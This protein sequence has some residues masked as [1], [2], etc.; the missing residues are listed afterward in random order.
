MTKRKSSADDNEWPERAIAELE[1]LPTHAWENMVA[2]WRALPALRPTMQRR[3]LA[4]MIELAAERGDP[5]SVK[6]VKRLNVNQLLRVPPR[7]RSR[8]H[9]QNAFRKAAEYRAA[10]PKA[11]W[12]ELAKAAGAKRDTVRQW[13]ESPKFQR[14]VR[15][16]KWRSI[17]WV[18][19][20]VEPDAGTQQPK[21]RGKTT[22]NL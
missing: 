9:D 7:P 6:L 14:L 12:D 17:S 11:S 18:G 16:A 13:E 4:R 8:V 10:N 3:I 5:L 19:T 2:L 15:D 20:V 1:K 21:R 22:S